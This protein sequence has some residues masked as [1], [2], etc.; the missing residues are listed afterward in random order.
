[1]KKINKKYGTLFW[2]TGISGSGKTT[3]AKKIYPE[4]NKKFG[5][6]LIL[7]G[8]DLRKI[9][10]LKGYSYEERSKIVLK[11]CKFAKFVTDQKINLIL[12]VIGMMDHVRNWNKRNIKNY[13]EIYIKADVKTIIQKRKKK[14]YLKSKKNI[15]GIDIKPE[16]PKKPDI[17]V[18]NNLN[19][20]I[21]S[22]KDELLKTINSKI[23]LN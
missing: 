13:I 8:D 14:I 12:A 3:I 5:P 7:S 15:V 4:I 19:K 20:S 11:Y 2:I 9:F 18:N 1:M 10:K 21:S 16:L 22:I 6:T 23:K 17:I